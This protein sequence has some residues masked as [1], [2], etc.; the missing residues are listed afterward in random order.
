MSRFQCVNDQLHSP[1]IVQLND[2][3]VCFHYSTL[4]DIDSRKVLYYLQVSII[5]LHNRSPV[6]RT[7]TQKLQ[8]WVL[9]G[10]KFC[11]LYQNYSD[12]PNL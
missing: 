6:K 11:L 10:I 9:Q 3:I 4:N 2:F 8:E 7:F 1:V 12:F 5:T